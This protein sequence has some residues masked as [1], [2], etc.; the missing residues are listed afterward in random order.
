MRSTLVWAVLLCMTLATIGCAPT[1]KR[2]MN[3]AK[4][5]EAN[6]QLGVAYFREG[7]LADAM[8]KLKKALEQKPDLPEAHAS[9]AVLYERLGEDD[10]A[11]QHYRRALSLAPKDSKI[12]NNYG[13]FLC[14]RGKLEQADK[15]FQ[16]AVT[17]PLYETP[18]AAYTNAGLCARNIPD[19]A[20]A[21]EYFR[22]AL[23]KNPLYPYAL[24]QMLKLSHDQGK[25]LRARAYLQRYQEVAPQTP[26]SLWY[27]I[28]VE[29]ALGDKDAVSSFALLLK[30]NFPDTAQTR[31][32]LEWAREHRVGQ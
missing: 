12:H 25:F 28:R 7:R 26:D 14:R 15:H 27:G 21:E 4:A 8:E 32:Y 11:A 6:V 10:L 18:E 16:A 19:E 22:K 1:N 5:A 3:A 9:I 23:S 20:R 31:D 13:Q 24:L 2:Q 17:D 29:H 30:N